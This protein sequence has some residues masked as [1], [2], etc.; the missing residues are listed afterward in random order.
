MTVDFQN[1]KLLK[2]APVNVHELAWVDDTLIEQEK[3]LLAFQGVRDSIL[4][5]N[6]RAVLRNVKGATGTEVAI[7]SI[8]FNKIDVFTIE[9][10]GI[11]GISVS[12]TLYIGHIPPIVME[13]TR[14]T[15]VKT[16]KGLLSRAVLSK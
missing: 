2:L 15:N 14:D 9:T 6:L 16:L 1:N 12:L 4:F 11:I 8:P 5:T 10:S 13:F 3:G 7:T